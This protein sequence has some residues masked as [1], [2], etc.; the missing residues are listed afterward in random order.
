MPIRKPTTEQISELAITL[1]MRLQPDDVDAY[2]ALVSGQLEGFAALDALPDGLPPVHYPRTPGSRPT[3]EENPLGAWYVRT[4][5]EGAAEGKLAGRGV[6]LKDNVM[7]GGVP[8]MNGTTTLEGYIPPMDATIVTRILDAGGTIVGKAACE[9]YCLSG[10]SHTNQSGVVRNPHDPEHS[11]GGSSS[12]SAVLVAAGEVDMAIGGDQGGSIRIPSSFCGTYGMKPTWGLVPY[13]GILGIEPT[14][15]HTGPITANVRDNALLLEVIAG[16]DGLDSR[17]VGAQPDAYTETLED[18]IEGLRIGLLREGFGLETS[19]PDVDAKVR[20]AGER[21][22]SLGAKIS[23]VSVPLHL[24][25]SAL[26]FAAISQSAM[27][28]M[29]QTDGCGT[30]REDPFP[31]SF[32]DLHRGWRDRADELPVTVKMMLLLAEYLTQQYG[33]RYQAKGVNLMRTLRAAYDGVLG[34]VDLL[35]LPTTP[36]KAPRLPPADVSVEESAAVSF[37][38]VANTQPF[39]NTHHPAMSI[40]CGM[41]HGLPVGAMLVGRPYAEATIYRAAHAFEAH[42]DWRTL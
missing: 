2:Q 18:G 38:M 32:L 20:A 21:L 10:S 24:S 9:A 16:P 5:V 23:E 4:R 1:G 12:G 11:A 26:A 28:T 14:I 22:A 39:N 42:T 31:P 13:T 41:S 40:P 27:H 29:F 36:M 35:L 15:D 6:V 33:Y 3:A 19:E 37:A 30:G 25:G 7:L 34:E 17:Q 8:L